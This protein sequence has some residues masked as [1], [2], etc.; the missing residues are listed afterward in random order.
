MSSKASIL[1]AWFFVIFLL[2]MGLVMVSST[3][4][5]AEETLDPYEPLYKQTSF[6]LVGLLGALALSRINYHIWRQYIWLILGVAC[7]LLILCY[8]PGIGKEINGERR[9]ISIGIQFQPSECAKLCMVMALAHWMALYRDKAKTFIQGAVIPGL[10]FGIPLALIFFEKDMGTAVALSLAGFCVMFVG[11]TRI[12]YLVSALIL[13]AG[14]LYVMVSGSENRMN[15]FRAWKD[16]AAHAQGQ[17]LQQHRANI[18]L[19]R[20]G[21]H[22]LGLGNSAEKH[23]KL[24]FAHTDF[25]YAPLGEE[26]GLFGTLSVLFSY[27]GFAFCGIVIALHCK[28]HFGRYMSVG[29]TS[30]VFCPAL[31]NIAVV[32]SA[33]P[34]TGLPLPFISYGGTNLVFTLA[35]LGMLTSIQRYSTSSQPD[36]KLVRKYPNSIDTKL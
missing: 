17:G 7:V 18:A 16:P 28:D 13:S 14:L 33:V 32:T 34:N 30:I 3:A 35:A 22:G 26:F 20:G 10:I 8:V 21:I 9:W 25:I 31:L 12:I 11:G 24:P 15:R 4:M 23:R 36:Y 27:G 1:L 19:T 29:I 6:A 2:V 5:W